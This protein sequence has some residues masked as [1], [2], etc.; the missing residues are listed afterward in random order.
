MKNNLGIYLHIPFCVRKCLYCDFLS[1]PADEDARRAYARALVREI[2]AYK[3]TGA[4]YETVSIFLGGGTPSVMPA[5]C[6]SDIMNAVK[7][8]FDVVPGAEITMEMNPG[9]V[10]GA[11]TNFLFSHVSRVSLGL[12]SA[13][14]AELAGLGRI[15]TFAEFLAA[16]RLLRETGIRNINV[17][18]MSGIPGQ[19]AES[20]NHTLSAVADLHPEHISAYSLIVEEGTP[21]AAMAAAG[22]LP[23][24]DED[25]ERK[26][27]ADTETI[28]S[29]RGYHRYEI[30]NYALPGYECRHNARYWRGGDYL[31]LGLG[32]SSLMDGVRWKNT[33]SMEE[34]LAASSRPKEILRDVET[35]SVRSRIEE[36]MFL[37]LRMTEGVTAAE[38]EKRFGLKMEEVYGGAIDKLADEGMLTDDGGRIRLTHRGVDVSNAVLAEFLIG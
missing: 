7:E 17:D 3:E 34:Y 33:D 23:I 27:Y 11:M 32:A 26:M 13:D 21:F 16:Y 35:L 36:F 20:W 15:H 24:P 29:L 4:A 18:L 28:L 22:K 37:G 14:D 8:T 9:T 6:L 12:Q 30:S 19:T 31:G 1:F 5:D 2:R 25:T 38:F 10:S